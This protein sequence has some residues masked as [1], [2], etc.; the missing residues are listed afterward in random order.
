MNALLV[1]MLGGT[2]YSGARRNR[3]TRAVMGDFGRGD[4]FVE[5]LWRVLPPLTLLALMS[6][7]GRQLKGVDMGW[8]FLAIAWLGGL[9]VFCLGAWVGV[10]WDPMEK[11]LTRLVKRRPVAKFLVIVDESLLRA[12][13]TSAGCATQKMIEDQVLG[14]KAWGYRVV[15]ATLQDQVSLPRR[16]PLDSV[17]LRSP[18][19]S[20]SEALAQV[21]AEQGVPRHK[22]VAVTGDPNFVR[23]AHEAEM[24][25]IAYARDEVSRELSEAH[26][27]VTVCT[28][29]RELGYSVFVWSMDIAD[30]DP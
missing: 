14:L 18:T 3:R 23:L 19:S 25:C 24:A 10:R 21:R 27:A 13:I 1:G 16:L 29:P 7:V 26:G 8:R 2:M 17:V 20:P 15:V 28:D 30:I 11:L 12:A 4:L 6:S 22:A 5:V 9:T